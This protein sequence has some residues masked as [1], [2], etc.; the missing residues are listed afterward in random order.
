MDK[1][2]YTKPDHLKILLD[3][4]EEMKEDIGKL[5]EDIENFAVKRDVGV[6]RIAAMQRI[7]KY[8]W[9]SG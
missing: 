5:R 3:E 9:S 1:E 7:K 8:N 6:S 4:I 2:N